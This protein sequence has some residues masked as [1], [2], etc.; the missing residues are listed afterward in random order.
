MN[1]FAI[2]QKSITC[3]LQGQLSRKASIC[4]TDSPSWITKLSSMS[5]SPPT[6]CK[7][8]GI[9]MLHEQVLNDFKGS[10][11]KQLPG[12]LNVKKH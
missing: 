6:N 10:E 8:I 2:I 9:D 7:N 11:F 12:K 1:H 5:N 3:K 4:T